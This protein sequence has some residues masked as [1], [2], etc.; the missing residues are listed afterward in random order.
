MT[1]TRIFGNLVFYASLLKYLPPIQRL[2]NDDWHHVSMFAGRAAVGREGQAAEELGGP[3]PDQCQAARPHPGLL[4][5]PELLPPV[6]QDTQE[7]GE[8][9]SMIGQE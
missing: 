4:P 6:Y 1:Q 8:C 7:T 9:W 2:L 3:G 5:E